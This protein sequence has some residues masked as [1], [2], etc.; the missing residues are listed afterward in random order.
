M[1][2]FS[3]EL[4]ANTNFSSFIAPTLDE[5]LDSLGFRQW[6]TVVASF[7]LPG[8][9]LFGIACCSL[10]ACIF[11][12]RKFADPIFFYYRLLCL[13]NVIHLALGIPY[14]LLLAPRYFPE[15]NTYLSTI[16][17]M[18]YEN[19]A[20]LLFHFEDTLQMAILLTRMKILSPYV[21]RHFTLK[22]KF[23]SLVFFL[24]CLGINFP[25]V[26]AF[27]VHSSGTYSYNDS[28]NSKQTST[29]YSVV[30]SDFSSTPFGQILYGLTTFFLNIFVTL[31]AGL[32]LNIVSVY[33]FKSYIRGKKKRNQWKLLEESHLLVTNK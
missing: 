26:F 28:N 7:V 14:G 27:K 24:V 15:V 21:N 30:P 2:N 16:Y 32:C 22:P 13:T 20:V 1:S 31:V 29:F 25:F 5:L 9:S 12:Q 6:L 23:V 11:F 4:D 10:S 33:Q 17:L 3:G 18:F 19:A 8:I